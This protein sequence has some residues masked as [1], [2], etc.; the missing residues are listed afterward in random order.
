MRPDHPLAELI[1][2]AAGGEF[3]DADGGWQRV[4]PWRAGLEAILS[5]TGHAVF[6]VRPDVPDRLLVALGADGFGG[7]HD[8]PPTR[9]ASGRCCR[10]GSCRWVRSSCSAAPV[11][12]PAPPAEDP[13]QAGALVR[14]GP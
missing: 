12:I 9:P 8:Q 10:P 5:F 14:K 7:A 6:A 4:P 2:A 11:T 3:P 13:A 1:I